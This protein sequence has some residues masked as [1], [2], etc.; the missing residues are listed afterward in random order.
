MVVLQFSGCMKRVHVLAS[1]IFNNV[2]KN[3]IIMKKEIWRDIPNYEGVYQVSNFGRIKSLSRIVKTQRVNRMVSERILSQG[4]N[5]NGYMTIHFCKNKHKKT[6]RVH[7]LVAIAFL[8]H[9]PSGMKL[10]VH[11]IDGNK[12]NNHVG[13]LQIITQ[14]ENTSKY[15]KGLTSKYTGVSWFKN[16]NKWNAQIQ[17]KGKTKYLGHFNNELQASKAYQKALSELLSR[18]Q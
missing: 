8:N 2:S 13:N 15:R 12:S 9:E 6:R 10:V 16:T 7:Q 5:K 1:P 17:I 14:R 4:F 18:K 11:H 3:V